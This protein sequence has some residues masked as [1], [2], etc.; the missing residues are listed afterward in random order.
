LTLRGWL[1]ALVL[2]LCSS[3]TQAGA[4]VVPGGPPRQPPVRPGA[5]DTVRARADTGR[6]RTDSLRARVDSAVTDTTGIANFLPPDSVMQRLM[7]LPGFSMTRYQGEIITFQAATRGA[8]LTN[9]AIVQRD[10]QIV[11][12]DTI[13]YN[14]QTGGVQAIGKR[15][16]FVVPGQAAPIV[17]TGVANYDMTERRIAGT[18]VKTAIEAEGQ[19]LFV[20][21]E[22]YVAVQ[23]SDSLRSANDINYYFKNGIVTACD[24]SIP[25]YYFKAKEIKRTGNFVVGRPAV[26][27]I[28][29][30]PVMW[31]PFVFQDVRGGRHSGILPPNVGVS[32]IIRNSPNYRRNVEG[33]G[34]YWAISDYVDAQTFIDW[35]S[36]A[37]E[38]E[39]GDPGYFRYNAELRY[40]W[41]D[42]YIAGNLAASQTTQGN[43]RNTAV[44]WGHQQSFTKNSSL[45]ANI[46]YA[47]N[48]IL[49]RETTSNP[50]AALATISSTANYQQKIGPAQ[51]SLGG[52]NRQY[53]GRS[54]VDRSFPTLSMSTS[55]ISLGS[56]LTW[57]PN[58]S[59]SSTQTLNIDQPSALGLFVR[60]EVVAGVDT[61]FGDTLKKNAYTS[62]FSFDTPLT[63]FGFSLGNR[64]T[65]NSARND[66][67]ERAI[68]ADVETGVEQERIYAQTY[69]TDLDWSPSFT[70][71]SLGRNKFNLTPS[72]S[73]SNVDGGA[74]WIRNERTGG[75][76]VHQ[77]KR[78]TYGVSASPTL[79]GLFDRGGR[80]FGPFARI[81]HVIQ[82][83]FGY[84]Y[85]PAA[86]VSDEYLAALGRTRA[87]STGASTGYLPSLAQNSLNVGLSTNIEAKLRSTVDSNPD[88]GEKIKLLS[89]NFT[90]IQYDF[91]RARATGSRIRGLTTQNFGY[92]VKSDL[93]PG[94]DVNVDYSLFEGSTMSDTARF[95]PYRERIAASMS[96]SNQNN[97]FA[98]LTRIFGKAVPTTTPG[99]DRTRPAPDDKYARQIASQPVAGRG[100]RTAALLPSITEGWQASFQFSSQ[101]QRPPGGNPSNVVEFD[102]AIRCVQFNT[103]S[104]RVLYDDCVARQ[105][106]NPSPE[107][108][109]TSG[110]AGSPFYRTPPTTSL[111]SSLSFKVTEKWAASWSTNYD[112]ERSSFASQ[113]VSLQR[114]LHDWRAI[115]AFTQSPNG[116]FAFNFLISLKA[117]PDLKF[118]YHKATYRNEGIGLQ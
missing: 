56:W 110:L 14:G 80:G 69:H 77:S 19:T 74:F 61:V 90:G 78:L 108:P 18:G 81:R 57:T 30:V 103:P 67:P 10:S 97:P 76:W 37:G 21:G 15:S 63:I 92:T 53:P 41:L 39:R 55:P 1:V 32:D 82:P 114:D 16:V 113:I 84:S 35:R 45:S 54:Q 5:P 47:T 99:T 11:K 38:T 111:N 42:R 34:Y 94:V 96:F 109:I 117:E 118:D 25:D 107:V 86:E 27:Y 95:K 28:G 26:L 106:T 22:K 70:L 31:L 93:L 2:V 6:A 58:L 75:Q 44:T 24:D 3:A 33:L 104:L 64:F 91:E 79:Y 105:L 112:F 83:T 20:T 115:F 36:S 101:R 88:A 87:S 100:A 29:D 62:S 48:T 89:V 23:L 66:F 9:R 13:V 46:N 102:P 71:P 40:R 59:Y 7:E 49:Q 8:S 4:Q 50:Y 17:T 85:A 43:S 116:S 65:I 98:M 60:R 68:V 73:L 51:F 12:A 52:T 72:V